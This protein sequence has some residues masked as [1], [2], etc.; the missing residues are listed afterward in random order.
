MASGA[1]LLGGVALRLR[2]VVLPRTPRRPPLRGR[3]SARAPPGSGRRSRS[4]T[5]RRLGQHGVDHPSRRAASA[6]AIAGSGT[7]HRDRCP[8]PPSAAASCAI[9]TAPV[10][11]DA[12]VEG[13]RG[14]PPAA[15]AR[16]HQHR[17]D[18][19]VQQRRDQ[20]APLAQPHPEVADG[21]QP[22]RAA[23]GGCSRHHLAEQ[24]GQRGPHGA[25]GTRRRPLRARRRA[26]AADRSS[27]RAP[28]RRRP[29][30]MPEPRHPG[31]D[32]PPRAVGAADAPRATGC[33]PARRGARRSCPAPR[34]VHGRSAPPRRTAARRAR[35]GGSRRRPRRRSRAPRGA[36]RP[37]EHVDADR[38]EPGER[39][40]EH[41]QLRLVHERGRQ[42]HA[43]LVP[44]RERFD[45]SPRVPDHLERL[46]QAARRSRARPILRHA[47]QPRRDR[48]AARARASSDRARAPPACTRTGAVSRRRPA[49]RASAP[50]PRRPAS[51]PSAIRIAVVL[52]APLRPT[53]PTM[54]PS[55][56]RR[57]RRRRAR[58][59]RRSGGADR[60]A[61]AR[62]ARI[63]EATVVRRGRR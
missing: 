52:P 47:A 33:G 19:D 60:S 12:E 11:D 37:D 7:R 29:P 45:P 22:P 48:R 13:R 32:L 25:E 16:E 39:L 17:D 24:L 34:R 38:I 46:E 40:V 9:A 6:W 44:E 51:T 18:A 61:R 43:L 42:L 1:S 20:E 54:R 55:R 4:P 2:H 35:A 23:V 58:R 36:A 56:N 50:R 41:Q 8:S 10:P 63:G 3:S 5:S 28:A 15:G 31:D 30:S 27:V 62:G 21:D 53:K 26:H 59:R 14:R 49:P 57:T